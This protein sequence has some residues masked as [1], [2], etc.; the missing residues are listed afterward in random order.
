M[1]ACSV[2]ATISAT[3]GWSVL[4]A[5]VNSSNEGGCVMLSRV[6]VWVVECG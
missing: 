2:D 6:W 5:A 1:I 4:S 3:S